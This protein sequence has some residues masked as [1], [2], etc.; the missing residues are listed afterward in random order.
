M[1][2]DTGVY[3]SLRFACLRSITRNCAARATGMEKICGSC[4]DWLLRECTQSAQQEATAFEVQNVLH[5]RATVLQRD[6]PVSG[7]IVGC[8]KRSFELPLIILAYVPGLC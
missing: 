8:D 4:M 1:F 5:L 6:D 7:C 2:E 3:A